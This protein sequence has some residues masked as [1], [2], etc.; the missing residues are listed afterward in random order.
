[1][2]DYSLETPNIDYRAMFLLTRYRKSKIR[3]ESLI[4]YLLTN[5]IVFESYYYVFFENTILYMWYS[6]YYILVYYDIPTHI[7]RVQK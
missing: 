4:Y 6:Y 1:M 3:I 7:K 5:N 2:I